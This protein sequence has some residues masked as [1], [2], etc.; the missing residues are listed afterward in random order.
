MRQKRKMGVIN[1]RG[2]FVIRPKY[3]YL[4]VDETGQ[5]VAGPPAF[6]IAERDGK[7]VIDAAYD[8]IELMTGNIYRLEQGEKIAY[9]KEDGTIIWDLQN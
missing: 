2:N 5:M 6:G 1:K 8:S 9:A 7:V 3:F 4:E